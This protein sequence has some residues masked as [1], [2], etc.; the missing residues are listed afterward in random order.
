M[1]VEDNNAVL[2][3]VLNAPENLL[4]QAVLEDVYERMS[5]KAVDLGLEDIDVRISVIPNRVY[6]F[7][8]QGLPPKEKS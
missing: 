6:R 4:T 5:V 1:R 3:L 8:P 7:D 2:D